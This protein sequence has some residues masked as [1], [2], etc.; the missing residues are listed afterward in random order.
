MANRPLVLKRWQPNMQFLKDDLVR[1]PVWVRL[2]NVPLEYW[3]IKGLSYI[4]SA[5][6]VP[7]HADRTTLLCKRL[8]YARVCVEIDASKMLVQE[9]DLRCSNEVFVTIL[10]DYEW[11]PPR[12]N[13][14]NI[15]GHTIVIC[16]TNKV[17]HPTVVAEGVRKVGAVTSKSADNKQNQFQWQVVV[18]RNKGSISG[19]NG[20]CASKVHKN[21]N[22]NDF[23]TSRIHTSNC[24]DHVTSDVCN[25]VCHEDKLPP[26]LMF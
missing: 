17:A 3:T 25:V 2:Y 6:R 18:K 1:V 21:E 26:L 4:A 8:S 23:S 16:T 22:E 13:N 14:Y 20:P 10:A 19:E 11:I 15:F 7:L 9:Y 24:N 5:I 12:C